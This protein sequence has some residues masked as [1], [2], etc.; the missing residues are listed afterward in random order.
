MTVDDDEA[1]ADLMGY[2]TYPVHGERLQARCSLCNA[3]SVTNEK[4]FQRCE[5]C[6]DSEE[7]ESDAVA[8]KPADNNK[9][10]QCL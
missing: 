4:G 9:E 1:W 3:P 5:Q 10:E 6:W 7:V 2:T 8:A